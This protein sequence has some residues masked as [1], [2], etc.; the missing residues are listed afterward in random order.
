MNGEDI[1]LLESADHGETEDTVLAY[2]ILL[3]TFLL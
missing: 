1:V 2:C 3:I